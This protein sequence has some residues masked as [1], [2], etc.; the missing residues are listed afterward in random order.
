M[1]NY[2]FPQNPAELSVP[3]LSVTSHISKI[4]RQLGGGRSTPYIRF[5]HRDKSKLFR[6]FDSFHEPLLLRKRPGS[7]AMWRSHRNS[8]T[9]WWGY[10]YGSGS[11]ASASLFRS[12]RDVSK[13]PFPFSAP[14][15]QRL[16]PA[17]A[18]ESLVRDQVRDYEKRPTSKGEAIFVAP[19]AGLEPAT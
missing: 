15:Y 19:A 12:E 3:I 1:P 5:S 14:P 7:R 6:D 13:L 11:W 17:T 4:L 8:P 18:G 16:P 10:F 9:R 2:P